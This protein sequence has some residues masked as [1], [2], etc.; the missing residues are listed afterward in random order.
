[1]RS[2]GAYSDVQAVLQAQRAKLVFRQ[3]TARKRRTD[4]VLVTRS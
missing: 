2:I 1:M 3:L 4:P